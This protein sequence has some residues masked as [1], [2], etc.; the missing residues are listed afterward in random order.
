MIRSNPKCASCGQKMAVQPTGRPRRFCSNAC[1]MRETRKLKVVEGERET[2]TP[3][4]RSKAKHP[5]V[6]PSAPPDRVAVLRETLTQLRAAAAQTQS[7]YGLASVAKEIRETLKEID[8]L[9]PAQNAKV[10]VFDELANRRSSKAP[11]QGG[12]DCA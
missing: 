10:T 7:A 11:D 4:E 1:R 5:S 8:E 2:V 9:A 3:L 6:A 12:P